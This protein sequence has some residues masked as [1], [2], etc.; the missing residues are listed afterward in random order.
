MIDKPIATNRAKQ[1]TKTNFESYYYLVFGSIPLNEI[2]SHSLF[3]NFPVL[4]FYLKRLLLVNSGQLPSHSLLTIKFQS[5][6][7]TRYQ[8]FGSGSLNAQILLGYNFPFPSKRC[9]QL[10]RVDENKKLLNVFS[11]IHVYSDLFIYL[12]IY[13]FVY[14]FI[15][16]FIYLFIYLFT[17]LFIYL[18]T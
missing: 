15:C 7:N 9:G 4:K 14:L 13:L 18:S 1:H 16:L 10:K 17:Y 12:F 6:D 2:H 11:P 3:Q 5:C 8:R